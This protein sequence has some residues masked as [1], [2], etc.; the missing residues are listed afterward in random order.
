MAKSEYLQREEAAKRQLGKKGIA[1]R[2]KQLPT[3]ARA[4]VRETSGVDVSRKGVSIDPLTVGL[5]IA[6]FV[7]GL[8]E[9]A[10]GARAARGLK[11]AGQI[12]RGLAIA[13]GA[14]RELSAAR[15]TAQ[16]AAKAAKTAS[17]TQPSRTTIGEVAAA[18]DWEVARPGSAAAQYAARAEAK[19]LGRIAG[20]G[21]IAENRAARALSEGIF[22]K[23]NV[24]ESVKSAYRSRA[25]A[26]NIG[27]DFGPQAAREIGPTLRAK[28]EGVFP[29][30]PDWRTGNPRHRT[31]DYLNDPYGQGVGRLQGPKFTEV[32]A[33]DKITAA[34]IRKVSAAAKR[35]KGMK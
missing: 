27:R 33:S 25:A 21:N 13:G 32:V 34:G 28:A 11:A 22:P 7:P 10:L 3:A 31:F 9:A 30:L 2:V 16:A 24:S 19:S 29:K 17:R 18:L 5:N 15:R 1:A 35:A 26:R 8:G 12:E 14:G 4:F 23:K 20:A 6:S